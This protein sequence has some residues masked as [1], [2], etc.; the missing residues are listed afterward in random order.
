MGIG[1]P[2]FQ[3]ILAAV[4]ILAG[5]QSG[6]SPVMVIAWATAGIVLASELLWTRIPQTR[7]W[8]SWGKLS[9]CVVVSGAIYL[10]SYVGYLRPNVVFE[11]RNSDP[12]IRPAMDGSLWIRARAYNR[13]WAWNEAVC[14]FYLTALQRGGEKPIIADESL[15]LLPAGGEMLTPSGDTP[16]PTGEGRYFNLAYIKK[17]AS[18]LTI[19]APQFANEYDPDLPPGTYKFMVSASGLGCRASQT[20]I[21]VKYNGERNIEAFQTP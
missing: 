7:F 21:T 14:R 9:I 1:L 20:K 6:V 19:Q 2:I 18:K 3:G 4:A 11:A 8:P 5:I 13:G 15:Q 17:G 16:I 10:V 12:F